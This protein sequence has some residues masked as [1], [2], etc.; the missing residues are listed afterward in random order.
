LKDHGGFEVLGGMEEAI[1][2]P[3]LT[4]DYLAHRE[5]DDDDISFSLGLNRCNGK[6][7]QGDAHQAQ[8]L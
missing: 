8:D 5:A 7:H 6:K 3:L 1:A 4:I 2:V